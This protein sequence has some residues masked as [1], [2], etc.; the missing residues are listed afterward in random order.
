MV[1]GNTGGTMRYRCIWLP[2]LA[3]CVHG[4][5]SGT[6]ST[7][8]AGADLRELTDLPDIRHNIPSNDTAEP[9]RDDRDGQGGTGV[10]HRPRPGPP[11]HGNRP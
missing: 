1:R 3:I 11:R 5:T 4:I 8:D 9:V 2:I 7:G 10:P 6:V